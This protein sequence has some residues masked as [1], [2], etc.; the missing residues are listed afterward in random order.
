MITHF[1]F[2]NPVTAFSFSPDSKFFVVTTEQKK[3]KIFISPDP[4]HKTYSPLI[5]YKKYGN[6]H[7]EEIFGVSW[8]NDS[9]F[10]LT[11]SSDLTMKMISLHKI[12]DFLPFTFSGNKSTIVKA[13]FSESNDKIIS[14]CANGRVN[15]WTWT[16]N[17][18]EGASK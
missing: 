8:S 3:C 7:S 10:I 17:K 18:S 1:N 16:E 14:I 9:R 12:K 6:L 2:R 11:W 13:Y 15:I 4:L 5:L